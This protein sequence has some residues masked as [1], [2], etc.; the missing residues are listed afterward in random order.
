[1]RGSTPSSECTGILFGY[2][3]SPVVEH[4]NVS[5]FDQVEQIRMKP[6][7]RCARFFSLARK[8]RRRYRVRLP[9]P[10]KH[11]SIQHFCHLF[12]HSRKIP[13]VHTKL[14]KSGV[15]YLAFEGL[16]RLFS[17]PLADNSSPSSAGAYEHITRTWCT[18]CASLPWQGSGVVPLRGFD[19]PCPNRNS[20][21]AYHFCCRQF[22]FRTQVGS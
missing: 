14:N 3:S 15:V 22:K 7:K 19:S 18:Q 8:V 21:R 11:G 16:F 20:C 6:N 9:C 1:M 12:S 4:L 13:Q 5:G 10:N 17:L 2:F